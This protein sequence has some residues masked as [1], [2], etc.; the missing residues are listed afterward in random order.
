MAVS[1]KLPEIGR[2]VKVVR[3]RDRG[4]YAVVLGHEGDRFIWIADG[5]ERRAEKPKKKNML[6]VQNTAHV[7]EEIV[8]AV[9]A[10]GKITNA[11]LR[12]V[13]RQFLEN[14]RGA[15]EGMEEGSVPDGE[16]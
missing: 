15:E 11:R 1:R 9:R 6:H 8:E 7:A 16:R 2:I 5:D 10:E 3:G 12:H 13:L 14:H 4:I